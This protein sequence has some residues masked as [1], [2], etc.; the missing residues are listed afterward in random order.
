MTDR[1]EL[2]RCPELGEQYCFDLERMGTVY[3]TSPVYLKVRNFQ[4]LLSESPGR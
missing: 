4:L 1:P 3:L 2:C